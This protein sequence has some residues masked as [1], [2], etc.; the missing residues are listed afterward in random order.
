MIIYNKYI[1]AYL[2]IFIQE[3]SMIHFPCVQS[4]KDFPGARKFIC[5][6]CYPLYLWRMTRRNYH[7]QGPCL[8]NWLLGTI[9]RIHE[10]APKHYGCHLHLSTLTPYAGC[11][12]NLSSYVKLPFIM[13][14]VHLNK[15]RRCT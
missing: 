8:G 15:E 6:V 5:L 4:R 1:S 13:D 10:V 7:I 9:Q 12:K 3:R 11:Q 14:T 2:F